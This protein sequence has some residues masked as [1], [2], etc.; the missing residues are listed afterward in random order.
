MH[1]EALEN[2]VILPTVTRKVDE[3]LSSAVSEE[4]AQSRKC[5]QKI[6]RAVLFLARQLRLTFTW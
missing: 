3:S 2:V 5:L 4:K 1:K 6:F